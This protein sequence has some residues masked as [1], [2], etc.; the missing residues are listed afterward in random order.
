[1]ALELG[2]WTDEVVEDFIGRAKRHYTDGMP[3]H[4]WARAE[5]MMDPLNPYSVDALVE[6]A[7]RRGV[8][9]FSRGVLRVASAWHSAGYIVDHTDS[10]L[11]DQFPTK[12]H[13]AA[14]LL[15]DDICNS[16][17]SEL[18]IRFAEEAII[19]T[20]PGA[21][22]SVLELPTD[23][24]AS[25]RY[26][27][28]VRLHKIVL[29][30]ANLGKIGSDEMTF[31]NAFMAMY[32]EHNILNPNDPISHGEFNRNFIDYLER[33]L[34]ESRIELPELGEELGKERSFDTNIRRN[35]KLLKQPIVITIPEL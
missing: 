14:R 10:I 33:I 7:E 18:G 34:E 28:E 2:G 4:N 16:G 8:S 5:D 1:M 13:Y 29:Q 26:K 19:G 9:L 3:Y 12:E 30:Y 31:I 20:A 15:S 25:E 35:L 22:R 24:N 21:D 11:A 23:P 32:R 6:R 17:V 27:T